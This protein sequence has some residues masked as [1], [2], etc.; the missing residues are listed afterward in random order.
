MLSLI[1]E[2]VKEL[3]HILRESYKNMLLFVKE[4]IT[5]KYLD[6]GT[7]SGVSKEILLLVEKPKDSQGI[8]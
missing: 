6:T 3:E 7:V 4:Y 1:K 8:V 5:L 2:E